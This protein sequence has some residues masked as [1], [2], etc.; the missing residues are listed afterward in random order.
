[1]KP[2]GIIIH[3]KGAIAENKPPKSCLN[4]PTLDN[5]MFSVDTSDAVVLREDNGGEWMSK[6]QKE[7]KAIC[8]LL[9][10]NKKEIDMRMQFF[11]ENGCHAEVMPYKSNVYKHFILVFE[12]CKRGYDEES[13]I[14]K[15]LKIGGTSRKFAIGKDPL[16][17]AAVGIENRSKW[18]DDFNK[19]LE[20]T[21]SSLK[22]VNMSLEIDIKVP[23]E[24][25]HLADG[26]L[27]SVIGD[28]K[29]LCQIMANEFI[30]KDIK[31][32]KKQASIIKSNQDDA[33]KQ[34][35]WFVNAN[36]QTR[37]E[38]KERCKILEDEIVQLKNKRQ[39]DAQK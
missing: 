32:M 17:E 29:K 30:A 5:R 36:E 14:E 19:G 28:A 2:D 20:R 15:L 27:E 31:K 6:D 1:M 3:M 11:C 13:G 8:L 9:N 4:H 24:A 37:K 34:I 21:P 22:Y 39:E 23:K 10:K 35:D 18:S 12:F 25:Q 33:Q 16:T 7:M 38:W 26:H